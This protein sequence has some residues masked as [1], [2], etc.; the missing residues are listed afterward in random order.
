[1]SESSNQFRVVLRGYDPGQVDR[2]VHELTEVT[3]A[4]REQVRELSIRLQEIERERD[5][6]GDRSAQPV[7]FVHLG[8]RVGQILSLAE[9]EAQVLRDQAHAEME[10]S[11]KEAHEASA[12]V[13]D[14]S[15]RYAEQRRS[16]AD[17]ESARVLEDAR[18][19]ADD[20]LDSA[21]RDAAARLQE[22]EAVYESQ[23][24]NAAKA[25]ADFETTLAKRRERAEQEFTEQMA[26]SQQQLEAAQS[27][28]E[29]ARAEAEQTQSDASREA[30]G[31]VDAAQ[32]Q[33]DGIVREAKALAARIRA[34]SE[35]ELE[36]ATQ[37]RDSI[38][39]QLSNVRQM[40]ATLS[41]A[42][43][44]AFLGHGLDEEPAP[45][46]PEGDEVDALETDESA[47]QM[48]AESQEP[49]DQD[50]QVNR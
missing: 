19:T 43:P 37:R 45:S 17:T 14:E 31:L 3:E 36:A 1:M 41:G 18:R 11:Q 23:R 30:Q 50:E 8:E 24:A 38:N 20:L 35:R 9:E 27:R 47:A 32:Q 21:E 2:R 42:A 34:E 6:A 7:S 16:N 46:P 39:A 15:D 5:E 12:R 4:A 28:T 22:A 49:A 33:A 44:G 10:A 40:L 48:P 26:V 29:Q 25:A 13:R